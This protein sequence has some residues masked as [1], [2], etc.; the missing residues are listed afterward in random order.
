MKGAKK[1]EKIVK[2]MKEKRKTVFNLLFS[3]ITFIS[4]SFMQ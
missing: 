2:I 1:Y 3:H 4:F